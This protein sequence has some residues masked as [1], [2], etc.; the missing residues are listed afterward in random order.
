[1]SAICTKQAILYCENYGD[2]KAVI[3]NDDFYME[4]I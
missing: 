4:I 1:M 3:C 2:D